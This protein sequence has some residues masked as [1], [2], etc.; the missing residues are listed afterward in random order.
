[1]HGQDL[2]EQRV[3]EGWSREDREQ[4]VPEEDAYRVQQD[5]DVTTFIQ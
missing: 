2:R 4:K 5:D 1:M 3:E